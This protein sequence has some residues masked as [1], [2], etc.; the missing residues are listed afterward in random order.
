MLALFT[1]QSLAMGWSLWVNRNRI[2]LADLLDR[3]VC[4]SGMT[5]R[6]LQAQQA[7]RK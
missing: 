4:G 3:P 7:K 1:V 2:T 5:L 6:E